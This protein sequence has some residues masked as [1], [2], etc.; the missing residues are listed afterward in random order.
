MVPV[1]HLR[2]TEHQLPYVITQYFLP[3]GTGERVPPQPQT[4]KPALDLSTP[5]K[6]KAKLTLVF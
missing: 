3:P 1:T 2:A 4:G 6:W 5:E